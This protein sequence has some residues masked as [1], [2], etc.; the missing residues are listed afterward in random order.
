MKLI[1][2][3]WL[4]LVL[5]VC[6]ARRFDIYLPYRIDFL[7]EMALTKIFKREFFKTLVDYEAS[8]EDA[9]PVITMPNCSRGALR[10]GRV[11]LSNSEEYNKFI[12]LMDDLAKRVFRTGLDPSTVSGNFRLPISGLDIDNS[13]RFIYTRFDPSYPTDSF[14]RF[15]TFLKSFYYRLSASQLDYTVSGDLHIDRLVLGAVL[16][17]DAVNFEAFRSQFKNF[18]LGFAIFEHLI[19]RPSDANSEKESSFFYFDSTDHEP[20]IGAQNQVVLN[21][22]DE[23]DEVE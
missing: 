3:Y 22:D 1:S 6:L 12:K 17:R 14:K 2:H 11:K 20:L 9:E 8:K 13:T 19:I 10:I 5:P 15:A 21:D 16:D 7:A 4:L 18:P 23:D